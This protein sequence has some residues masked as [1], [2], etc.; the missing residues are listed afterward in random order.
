MVKNNK[1]KTDMKYNLSVYWSFAKKHKGLFGFILILVLI[2]EAIKLT[3]KFLFKVII[4]N[5]TSFS[6]GI[7]SSEALLKIFSVV[8]IIYFSYI[9]FKAVLDWFRIHCTNRLD[10]SLMFDLK[11]KFFNHLVSLSHSFHTSNKT[12]SI[13]SRLIRGASSMERMTDV[14]LYSFAPIVFQLIIVS[15]SLIYFSWQPAV[16]IAV[17]TLVF[18]SYSIYL[19]KIQQV[20][21]L[22]CNRAEDRE[23]GNISDIFTNIES[24]KYFGKE[25]T[26]Q[27]RFRKLAEITKKALIKEWNYFRWL[28]A[29]QGLILSLGTFFVIYFPIMQFIR[30]E[31]TL[32]TLVFIYTTY[33][34]LIYPLFNFVYGIKN[35]YRSMADFQ[36]LF[37]YGK[38]PQEVKD[39]V[40]AKI[41]KVKKG[42]IE[43]NNIN[44]GYNKRKVFEKFYLRTKPNE[45]IALVGHSGCG[46]TTLVKLLYRLYDVDEGGILI[47]G[48]DIRNFKQESLRSEMSIVPQEA[49]L[50]D[51]TIYNNI[52]FANPSASREEVMQAI[53]F[54]QLDKIIINFPKKENT[55]VGERGV[56]LSGGEKQRVSIARAILANKKILV[57]DEATSA[58]DSETEFEIQKDLKKLLE[59]RTSVIIAHRLSTIMHADRIIVMKNGKIVQQGKHEEL[60]KVAGEYS[61]LWKLQ[62]GGY[63]K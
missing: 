5:G 14:I 4:D 44:F 26:I 57:L 24:V 52:K 21:N 9:L 48:E 35:Y 25:N 51:D 38:V 62:K 37:E 58:L 22:E 56:K 20:A 53:Q 41:F 10:S 40:G 49:I 12:G 30:G 36:P 43:F 23:K 8:A 59:G 39:K 50:F 6:Q 17:M 28:D 54:A 16:V 1:E 27:N 47:D 60:I 32:G 18:I 33:G 3:D 7:L 45:K 11:T 29:G 55:I 46:K 42:E 31:L 63:I 61:K 13:I 34:N 19:Q 2:T 15:A